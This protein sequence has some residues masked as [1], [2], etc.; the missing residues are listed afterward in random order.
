MSAENKPNM[1]RI[2]RRAAAVTALEAALLLTGG[3]SVSSVQANQPTVSPEASQAFI[4]QP[5]PIATTSEQNKANDDE[6][7]LLA[8][9][10][11]GI[12]MVL[13]TSAMLGWKSR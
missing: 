3:H 4:T 1:G 5:T 6:I 9:E 10:S 7:T 8:L 13:V 2:I 11:V 12:A